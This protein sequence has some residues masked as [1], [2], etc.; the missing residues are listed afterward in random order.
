MTFRHLLYPN[1]PKRRDEV[2]H[3]HQELFNCMSANVG[4]T[5]RL[6]QVLNS[7]LHCKL[8]KIDLQYDRS[9]KENCDMFILRMTEIQQEVQK[10]DEKL[11]AT[12]EPNLYQKLHD[13]RESEPEKIEI[14]QKV[15]SGILGQATTAA[16][17]III[18]LIG[19]NVTT[20]IVNKLLALLAQISASVLGTIG[21]AA[22]GLGID[23]IVGAILGA[24]E[25]DQLEASIKEYESYLDEFK[26]ASETYQSAIRSI[27]FQL[28]EKF[29]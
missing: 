14:A 4:A 3:L 18:K 28:E 24:V 13:I 7:N 1:N 21:V 17:A 20:V 25:R 27:T 2:I 11:K 15:L 12:L 6:I 29:H 8:A 26:P 19:S 23:V 5:N 10:I 9:I 16:G 22:F